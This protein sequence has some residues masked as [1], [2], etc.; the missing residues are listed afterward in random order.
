MTFTERDEAL[1]RA[2][3]GKIRLA[4]FG[5]I[6]Q[7]WW[8]G[9]ESGR[10]NARRRVHELVEARLLIRE[11]TFARPML[12]LKAPVF[13][14]KPGHV[15][16][17][18]EKLSYQLQSRWEAQDGSREPRAA[19]VYLASHRAAHVLGGVAIARIQNPSQVTHDIHVTEIYLKLLRE[20]PKLAQAWVGEEIIAPTRVNQKLPDAILRDSQGTPRLVMEFG[21]A[22]PSERVQAFHEDCEARGLPYE[23]W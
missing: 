18:P 12:E 14:W 8:P 22:Y 3:L 19:T 21:G 15:K 20:E 6:A 17:D 2:L 7:A 9:S 16:P 11:R 13:R 5:Q 10:T 1:V 4:S 23:L